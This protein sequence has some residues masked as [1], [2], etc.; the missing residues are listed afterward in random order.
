MK[1]TVVLHQYKVINGAKRRND[2][3]ITKDV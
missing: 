1:T 3:S 2:V